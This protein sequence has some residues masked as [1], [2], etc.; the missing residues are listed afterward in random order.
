MISGIFKVSACVITGSRKLQLIIFTGDTLNAQDITKTLSTNYLFT[1]GRLNMSDF[2]FCMVQ[3]SAWK[4][5]LSF[6]RSSDAVSDKFGQSRITS[7]RQI[8]PNAIIDDP[9]K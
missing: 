8:T 5:F 2:I 1:I 3:N 4:R 7:W 6:P 9:L